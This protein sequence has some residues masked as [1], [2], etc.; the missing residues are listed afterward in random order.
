MT[1]HEAIPHRP[2]ADDF[3]VRASLRRMMRA[4]VTY[5]W[6]VIGV[7]AVVLG[8]MTAYIVIWPKVY[9]ARATVTAEQRNDAYRDD[10]YALWGAL[11]KEDPKTE[12]ALMTASPVLK[13]VVREL[14]LTYDDV[15]HPPLSHLGY[16][17]SESWVGKRYRRAKEYFFPPERGPYTP[18]Q[19]EID[20]ARTV[21]D[22]RT[23]VVVQGSGDTNAGDLIVRGPSPRVAEIAN[24]LIEV[25]FEERRER[26]RREAKAAYDALSREVASAWKDLRSIEDQQEKYYDEQS[27]LLQ[28][29]KDK[30]EISNMINLERET[31]TDEAEQASLE[32]SLAEVRRGMA[33]E[34]ERVVASRMTSRNQLLETMKNQRFALD[35]ERRSLLQRYLPES[36]EIREL[37]DRIRAIDEAISAEDTQVESST[38]VT[39]S[40]TYEQLRQRMQTL[41]TA[42]AG[43]RARLEPKRTA[44]AVMKTRLEKVPAKMRMAHDLGREQSIRQKKFMLLQEKQMTA[45]VFLSSLDAAPPSLQVIAFAEP[46]GKPTWPNSKLLL[47]LAAAVGVGAGM[48][49]AVLLDLLRGRVS[50]DHL[51]ASAGDM[52]YYGAIEVERKRRMGLPLVAN[53][54]G[55]MPGGK[56]R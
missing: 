9:I 23:G 53:G 46:P 27:L 5:R 36:R 24:K 30:V 31:L 56:A 29:E 49:L 16:L 6:V 39:L 25:Y 11:R 10:F 44:L 48:A 38:T 42:L 35:T 4:C 13:R 19:E 18:T 2:G 41:E 12:A 32:A 54:N 26:Q 43:V 55:H 28:F 3:E 15:Y 47:A 45:E 21:D 14:G 8:L 33:T 22:F 1:T 51:T 17:W 40:S 52:T 37:D 50:V 7:A 20:F 34:S